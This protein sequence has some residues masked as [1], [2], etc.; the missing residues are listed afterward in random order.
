[1]PFH[2]VVD[3]GHFLLPPVSLDS[4]IDGSAQAAT[5][6]LRGRP[7]GLLR[8]TTSPRRNSSPPHTPQG[9]RRSIAPARHASLA[10]Q[11]TQSAF[12]DSTSSGD[13][14]KNSSGSS[15]QGSCALRA[16]G[17]TARVTS[18]SPD[19]GRTDSGA[20]TASNP[21]V[22]AATAAVPGPYIVQPLSSWSYRL[23]WV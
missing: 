1:M 4:Q 23:S 16:A 17:T 21:A 22:P 7:R 15:V 5:S 3:Q 14:A 20:E 10:A 18:V 8:G 13:S 9:S 6:V 11:S 19:P 12:A 2:W